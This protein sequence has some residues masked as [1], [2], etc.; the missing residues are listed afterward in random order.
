MIID[1]HAVSLHDVAAVRP[2][3]RRATQL[4]FDTAGSSRPSK[5]CLLSPISGA[6]RAL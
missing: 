5:H 6:T 2:I 1:Q 4:P 3:G